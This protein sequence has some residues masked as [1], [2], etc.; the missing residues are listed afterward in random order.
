MAQAVNKDFVEEL[1]FQSLDP[2]FQM[3][4]H[5]KDKTLDKPIVQGGP[6][7]K[8]GSLEGHVGSFFASTGSRKKRLRD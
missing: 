8:V 5:N 4:K 3:H 2:S 1:L 7:S 6:N